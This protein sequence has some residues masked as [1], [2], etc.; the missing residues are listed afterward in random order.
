M[1]RCKHFMLSFKSPEK[2]SIGWD[3]IS[4]LS[5]SFLFGKTFSTSKPPIPKCNFQWLLKFGFLHISRS[6]CLNFWCVPWICIHLV[7]CCT[8]G[9]V[10][11]R[12]CYAWCCY[13]CW[14]LRTFSAKLENK[15]PPALFIWL[16]NECYTRYIVCTHFLASW[17]AH[18]LFISFSL[19]R[20]VFLSVSHSFSLSV[21]LSLTC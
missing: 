19:V 2:T 9:C 5:S 17:L 1:C 13:C 15:R 20:F 18:S 11:L 10:L 7:Y 12:C 8:F 3:E 21:H 6:H 14:F 4:K 16:A